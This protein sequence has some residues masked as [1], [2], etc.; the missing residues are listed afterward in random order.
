MVMG[1]N[2]YGPKWSWSEMVMGRNDPESIGQAVSE[3]FE[4]V[5]DGRA[6]DGR[7]GTGSWLYTI[8]SPDEVSAQVS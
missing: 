5:D 8:S 1:R 6:D 2:G 3:M 7:T 4:I